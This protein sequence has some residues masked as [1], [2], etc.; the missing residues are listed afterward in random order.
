VPLNFLPAPFDGF[1]ID[2]NITWVTS[3]IQVQSRPGVKLKFFEQPDRA[4]NAA[5]YYQKRRFAARVAYSYQTESLRQIGTDVLRD[6]Y[7]ADHYQTD[8][9]ASFKLTEALALFGNVQNITN[10]PQDT[11]QGTPNWLRFRR[12]FGWNARFGVKFRF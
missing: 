1:G 5:L 3:S 11:Y 6:F 2:G 7:R 12:T 4:I 10:Q 9:Q 8:A